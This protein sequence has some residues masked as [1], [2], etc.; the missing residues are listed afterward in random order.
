LIETPQPLSSTGWASVQ[1]SR[2]PGGIHVIFAC[3]DGSPSH[4]TSGADPITQVVR[5]RF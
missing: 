4:A 2:L 3:Y 1:T 5:P